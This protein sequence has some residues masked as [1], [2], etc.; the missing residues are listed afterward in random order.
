M[1]ILTTENKVIDKHWK[2]QDARRTPAQREFVKKLDENK[3]EVINRV[4]FRKGLA[5]T[6]GL[7]GTKR[8]RI[9]DGEAVTVWENK[10][11]K[12]N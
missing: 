1:N 7:K 2:D 4:R 6:R 5:P 10:N 3:N 11:C 9:I 12:V 8:I